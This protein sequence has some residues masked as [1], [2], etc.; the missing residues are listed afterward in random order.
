VRRPVLVFEGT[1]EGIVVIEG[2]QITDLETGYRLLDVVDVFLESEFG[3]VRANDRDSPIFVY[4]LSHREGRA[5][6]A[7]N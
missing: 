3:C 4:F 1:P 5:R 7:G 2:D 6:R